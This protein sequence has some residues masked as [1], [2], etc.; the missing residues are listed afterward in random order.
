MDQNSSNGSG[1]S[2]WREKLG[3][4][5]NVKEMPK[6]SQ[7][8]NQ[9]RPQAKTTVPAEPKLAMKPVSAPEAGTPVRSAQPVP[10][11]APMAPRA[12]ARAPAAAPAQRI[13]TKAP[14]G[15]NPLAEKLRAQRQAAEL[16]AEQ[17]VMQA[18]DRAVEPEAVSET[19][20]V[21]PAPRP[22]PPQEKPKFSFAEEELVQ[23]KR[24]TVPPAPNSSVP[25]P[26]GREYTPVFQQPRQSGTQAG[27]SPLPPPRQPLGGERPP[28]GFADPRNR[29]ATSGYQP[30][31][32]PPPQ[33][34]AYRPLDPP[35]LKRPAGPPPRSYA[36]PQ[37]L[38]PR[39]PER[40][41]GDPRLGAQREAYEAYRRGLPPPPPVEEDE[42]LFEETPRRARP[43]PPRLQPPA[44]D[45][46]LSEVFEEGAPP[47]PPRRRASVQEYN[48]AYREFEEDY[49]EEDNRRSSGPWLLLGLLLIA[50]IVTA[51][52]VW[53]YQSSKKAPTTLQNGA[54][55]EQQVPVVPAPEQPAKVIPEDTANQQTEPLA[56]T[57]ADKKKQIYDRIVG[58]QE[59]QGSDVVPTVEQPLQPEAPA[60]APAAAAPS[61]TV[62]PVPEPAPAPMPAPAPAAGSTG[63]EPVPTPTEAA[64]ALGT[65]P[66][67]GNSVEPLPLPLPPPP[68]DDTQGALPSQNS[69]QTVA[70]AQS[71]IPEPPKP[72]A[73]APAVVAAAIPEPDVPEMP[74]PAPVPGDGL[75]NS[76]AAAVP[77]VSPPPTPEPAVTE[78]PAEPAP[79]IAVE[80]PKKKVAEKKATTKKAKPESTALGA[81]PVVLVPPASPTTNT[82]SL[83][84]EQP[85]AE[86]SGSGSFFKLGGSPG[87]NALKRIKDKN[88]TSTAA[89]AASSA[90]RRWFRSACRAGAA[91]F[92]GT[93]SC[94]R[95]RS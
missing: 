92:P 17:R 9:T 33:P 6:V 1:K 82:A 63:T 80:A 38:P 52:G 65:Q 48:Q 13:V 8:I 54:A 89:S 53:F 67:D 94:T 55:T 69:S 40:P 15:E 57:Q 88:G 27:P 28:G 59:I 34:Q 4:G 50:A 90:P 60:E 79:A 21:A 47:P 72:A 75:A 22:V 19:T 71:I 12:P 70:A 85:A 81:E 45:D 83:A 25:G 87:N 24:E 39:Y 76:G 44:L 95:A 56:P 43:A 2:N 36:P 35:G 66:A 11:P 93:R 86:T 10:R 41:A 18:R 7:E 77:Q 32:S 91:K 37:G 3:I 20:V 23:A 31:F 61:P 74:A 73:V 14:A 51:G 5:T 78:A 46:E 58:D 49:A 68:G 62:V 84:P 16:A 64:P 29:P 42:A 30:Q 26:V